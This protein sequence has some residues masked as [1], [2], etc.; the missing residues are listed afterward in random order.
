MSNTH[1]P[2]GHYKQVHIGYGQ[3]S[4]FTKE[5]AKDKADFN[6]NYDQMGSITTDIHK[7]KVSGTNK[8]NTFGVPYNGYGKQVIREAPQF[9]RVDEC[10]TEL[11]KLE[12]LTK[13][14]AV[15]KR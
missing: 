2:N 4:D 7:R 14:D 6:Y 1:Q 13:A 9:S 3:R 10:K 11:I 12:S 8:D 15:T 5:L